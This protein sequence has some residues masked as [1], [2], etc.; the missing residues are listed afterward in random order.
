ML[1]KWISILSVTAA[2]WVAQS[3]SGQQ[4]PANAYETGDCNGA[5][6]VEPTWL[7]KEKAKWDLTKQHADLIAQRN[8]AW[9]K[10]FQCYDRQ[11]YFSLWSVASTAGWCNECTLADEH[12]DA[13][14]QRLNR[15]GQAK[16][17]GIMINL[18][19][20]ARQVFVYE[21]GNSEVVDRRIAAVNELLSDRYGHLQS[22]PVA[23]TFRRPM[24]MSGTLVED[25][26]TK[27][28]QFQPNPAVPRPSQDTITGR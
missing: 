6:Q 26:Q 17:A 13:D 18:P 15:A 14:S 8:D 9:P 10:P 1:R 3:A 12:F 25:I 23:T 16:L 20:Q 27:F 21:T 22:P 28:V 11:A 24:G 4:W 7:E 5:A 2:A 19:P